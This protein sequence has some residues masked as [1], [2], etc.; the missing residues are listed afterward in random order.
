MV[1]AEFVSHIVDDNLPLN[2]LIPIQRVI[3]SCFHEIIRTKKPAL[4]QQ[5]HPKDLLVY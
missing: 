4:N 1:Q 3:E 2:H 5:Y